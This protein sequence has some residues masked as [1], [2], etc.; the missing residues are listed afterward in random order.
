MGYRDDGNFKFSGDYSDAGNIVTGI[1][2]G[3]FLFPDDGIRFLEAQA[4]LDKLFNPDSTT[5]KGSYKIHR[6]YIRNL[7][8]PSFGNVPISRCNFQFN[9]QQINQSVA[10]RDDIYLPLLQPPEQLAQPIGANTNFS[11]DLF[12]DRSHEL[13]KGSTTSNGVGYTGTA[14]AAERAQQSGGLGVTADPEQ[15]NQN[16]PYDIGVMGDLRVFY[17]VI[18]QGFSR[19]MLDFQ[20]KMFEYNSKK[21]W[22]SS[23]TQPDVTSTNSD[24]SSSEGESSD[25]AD[26]STPSAQG[27]AP[28]FSK[29]ADIIDANY[30]NFALLMPNPVRIVFSNLFM[31]DGFITSTNVDFLKFS[32]NMVPVQCRI[33]ITMNAMYIG[34]AKQRTFLTK[35]FEDAKI[36]LDRL[37]EEE[38][39]EN[40]E[41]SSAANYLDT[42]AIG[43]VNGEV[44]VEK[45]Q[46]RE[47]NSIVNGIGLQATVQPS[48]NT[49]QVHQLKVRDLILGKTESLYNNYPDG[50]G[51]P[52][53]VGPFLNEP[54]IAVG[55]PKIVPKPGSGKD[56]DQ[57]LELFESKTL[58]VSYDWA[59]QIYGRIVKN[60]KLDYT[61]ATKLINNGT[62]DGEPGVLLLGKYTGSA[63][64][65]SKEEWGSGEKSGIRQAIKNGSK[66][67]ST[68]PF[69]L[70]Y[71]DGLGA[72][73]GLDGSGWFNE[74]YYVV[75]YTANV[76][77]NSP[78]LTPV[79]RSFKSVSAKRGDAG[80]NTRLFTSSF[81]TESPVVAPVI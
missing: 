21:E 43:A 60:Q 81:L 50:V 2:N 78:N 20:Q 28:D 25:S 49:V 72:S 5:A 38:D 58:T 39:S 1:E 52:S 69:L 27:D 42:F 10:M 48:G 9:P 56:L 73:Y 59:I 53:L 17:S 33:G 30:G 47:W 24:D 45:N 62:Y 3:P 7:E 18:G 13:A 65:S 23:N 74:A 55:F 12:F 44:Y 14:D 41:N 6:G 64:C 76:S 66:N 61:S 16:D 51:F 22:D 34:F 29:I 37:N 40:L 32:S 68:T 31:V 63:T 57:V 11:F 19:E 4:A 67:E 70:R 8:Q 26:T 79:S 54:A 80:I 75:E 15:S 77:I 35:V 36:E 46:Y 71:L